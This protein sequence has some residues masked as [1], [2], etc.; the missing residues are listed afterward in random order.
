MSEIKAQVRD[1][2]NKPLFITITTKKTV[3]SL[4]NGVELLSIPND[5]ILQLASWINESKNK[6]K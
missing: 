4:V 2:N 1:S 5:T 6:I 3:L